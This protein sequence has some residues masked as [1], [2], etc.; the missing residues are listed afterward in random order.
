MKT[1]TTTRT[2]RGQDTF[3]S[4]VEVD[5]SVPWEWADT[6][7]AHDSWSRYVMLKREKK[8]KRRPISDVQIGEFSMRF[9][10]L[11]TRNGVDFKKLFPKLK[12]KE[13]RPAEPEQ[14]SNVE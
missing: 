13:P 1:L 4:E 9:D 11:I 12:I 10:G 6:L 2:E 5:F 14:I 3:L 8:M 7:M